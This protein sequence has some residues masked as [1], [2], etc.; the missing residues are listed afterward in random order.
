MVASN[1]SICCCGIGT[2]LCGSR[3]KHTSSVLTK[4]GMLGP[5]EA[6]E[7][8]FTKAPEK[9][10]RTFRLILVPCL[11]YFAL[12]APRRGMLKRPSSVSFG[13]TPAIS[14]ETISTGNVA[15]FIK[16]R[17]IPSGLMGRM[18]MEMLVLQFLKKNGFEGTSS[19]L[20]L[21]TL[22]GKP[23][24][25]N[26][27]NIKQCCGPHPRFAHEKL[28]LRA[29]STLE[30]VSCHYEMEISPDCGGHSRLLD[31]QWWTPTPL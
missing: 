8:A 19:A 14:P 6:L 31:C 23:K 28:N 7:G 9:A 18:P 1:A 29:F 10:L 3:S 17:G 22:K 4:T 24:Q 2:E 12:E 11:S 16:S 21:I 30:L 26:T 13:R 20:G 5:F 27:F 25:I 15:Q